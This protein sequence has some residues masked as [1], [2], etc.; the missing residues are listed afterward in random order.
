M[1]IFWGYMYAEDNGDYK[2]DALNKTD[3]I[4]DDT[5]I[6]NET[7]PDENPDEEAPDDEA[8]DEESLDDEAFDTL[9]TVIAADVTK[10]ITSAGILPYSVFKK[11]VY[12]LLGK[13]SYEPSYGDSDRWSDFFGRLND[14]ETVEQGA[15][16]EFYEETAGCIMEMAEVKERITRGD[17]LLHS[18]LHPRKSNSY[19]TY[20]MLIAY[21]DYPSMFRRT[22]HFIQ[23]PLVHGDISII[24]KSQLQWFSYNEVRDIA[25]H[26]WGVDR[27]RRRPRFRAKFAEQIRR[28]MTCSDLQQQCLDSYARNDDGNVYRPV[29]LRHIPYPSSRAI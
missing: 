17:Y 29:A 1:P 2:E 20:L 7:S 26:Q 16:R 13:E 11:R 24:E 8:I 4:A 12:F 5:P 23:Y 14:G 10:P 9:A 21:K 22:K 18:E 28:I 25:F 27:Y 19:R 3:N 15:C 6:L